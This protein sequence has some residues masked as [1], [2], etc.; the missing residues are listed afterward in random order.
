MKTSVS[1]C[2][3]HFSA[4]QW[5]TNPSG[6]VIVAIRLRNEAS[7]SFFPLISLSYWS[8]QCWCNQQTEE[9]LPR[10]RPWV[11]FVRVAV[12]G[13]RDLAIDYFAHCLLVANN[14]LAKF[15]H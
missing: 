11:V 13:G 9:L 8:H 6:T 15:F 5:V 7:V 10:F 12:A 4:S 14:L 2:P 1:D 3:G